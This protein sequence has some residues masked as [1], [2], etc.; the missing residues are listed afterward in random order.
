MSTQTSFF[1]PPTG[2][3]AKEQARDRVERSRPHL[4]SLAREQAVALARRDPERTCTID[5]VRAAMG[6]LGIGDAE[7]ATIAGVVFR[8]KD[9]QWTGRR[10]RSKRAEAHANE[11][12]VWQYV[13][14]GARTVATRQTIAVAAPMPAIDA[15]E[16]DHCPRCRRPTPDRDIRIH[17][18]Q[19][20]R[21]ECRAC[22]FHKGFP[23]WN[24]PKI[25]GLLAKGREGER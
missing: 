7:F 1:D 16:G 23:R 12:R 13:G 4:L 18:G 9:W 25:L 17:G 11:Q 24:P 2:Q 3:Q 20:T 10:V 19:S 6:R 15:A 22:N 21:R 5:Q 8:G 14:P